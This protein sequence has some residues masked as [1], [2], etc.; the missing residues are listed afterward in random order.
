MD[1][2][3]VKTDGLTR[4]YLLTISADDIKI[5]VEKKLTEVGRTAKIAGF[6]PGKIPHALLQQR[7]QA[8]VLPDVLE[9]LCESGVHKIITDDNLRPALKPKLDVEK[10]YEEGNSFT[11]QVSLELLPDVGPVDLTQFSIEQWTAPL[12]QDQVND[13]LKSI[14][15]MAGTHVETTTDK[16]IADGDLVTVGFVG[17]IDGVPF[18][19]GSHD[20]MDITIGSGSMIPGFEEQMVGMKTGDKKQITVTFPTDYHVSTL[21]GKEATFDL[22]IVGI[23]SFVPADL[24][25]SLAKKMGK[26]TLD[27]LKTAVEKVQLDQIAEMSF[28]DGKRKILDAMADHFT[29]E[30]PKG[31]VELEFDSIWRQVERE[32]AESASKNGADPKQSEA[33]SEKEKAEYRA[34]AE[35]RVRLGLVLAEIGKTE[36]ITV[37]NREIQTEISKQAGRYPGHEKK[38]IDYYVNNPNAVAAIRAPLFEDKVIQVIL[39]KAKVEKKEVTLDALK[40]RVKEITEGDE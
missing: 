32:K 11:C 19:G 40:N 9:K 22:T 16:I 28:L 2:K 39:D 7:Y 38:V 26:E 33:D 23:K 3:Q 5:A 10:P 31:L 21:K 24:D 1:A 18:D 29:F 6:R 8:S 17:K 13:H 25:D 4:E 20:G 36:G 12:S 35:R 14:Q 37:S 15:K 27:E 30:L 34:L